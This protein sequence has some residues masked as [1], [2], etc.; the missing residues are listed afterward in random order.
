[1]D[2]QRFI[3][4]LKYFQIVIYMVSL[5]NNVGTLLIALSQHFLEAERTHVR[6]DLS[7]ISQAVFFG[8]SF[9]NIFPP[10]RV[11]AVSRPNRKLLLFVCDN[12]INR[13]SFFA[14]HFLSRGS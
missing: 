1:M 2:V 9:A 6:P 12:L 10:K 8:A 3:S 4:A 7:D 11:R 14:G 13:L 5:Y